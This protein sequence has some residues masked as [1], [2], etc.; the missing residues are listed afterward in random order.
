MFVPVA[1]LKVLLRVHVEDMSA[2]KKGSFTSS[3]QIQILFVSFSC[4]ISPARS[5][6]T[7]LDERGKNIHLCLVADLKNIILSPLSMRLAVGFPSMSRITE[8]VPSI[9]NLICLN[10]QLNVDGDLRQISVILSPLW[11]SSAVSTHLC[12]PKHSGNRLGPEF[13]PSVAPSG[14]PL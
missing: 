12:S 6:S 10:F 7:M 13:L 4:L 3:F 11:H 2:A 9:L 8:E 1:F 5:F 14:N